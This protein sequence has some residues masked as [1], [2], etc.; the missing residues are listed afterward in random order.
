M[1]G[2][3]KRA[4]SLQSWGGKF[5]ETVG[6]EREIL[7]KPWGWIDHTV[8]ARGCPWSSPTS[9]DIGPPAEDTLA[10]QRGGAHTHG[11]LGWGFFY[12]EDYFHHT[13]A[14]LQRSPEW[15]Q[16][17]GVGALI[18]ANPQGHPAP[19]AAEGSGGPWGRSGTQRSRPRGVFWEGECSGTEKM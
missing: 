8:A 19:A 16:L 15:P 5:E 9:G 1:R 4:E 14:F 18:P 12:G 6:E 17:L 3:G 2:L 11:S 13:R 10:P 7:A